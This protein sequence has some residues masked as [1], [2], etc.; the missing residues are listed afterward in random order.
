MDQRVLTIGTTSSRAWDFEAMCRVDDANADKKSKIAAGAAAVNYL[1]E[2]TG[3]TDKE[4]A[5]LSPAEQAAL[6][7]KCFSWYVDDLSEA[8][9]NV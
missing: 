4:I 5:K 2:G 6:A 7:L 1:F 9:K 8:I 3:I